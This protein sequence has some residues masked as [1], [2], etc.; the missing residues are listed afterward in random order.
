MQI[1]C[2][3]GFAAVN[4]GNRTAQFVR[5][6]AAVLG[7]KF[8]F[9]ELPAEE[10]V[11]FKDRV[12]RDILPL[13]SLEVEA[14][15]AMVDEHQDFVDAIGSG[16]RARVDARAGRDAV[17]VAEAVLE[18]IRTHRWPATGSDASPRLDA[19]APSILRPPHWQPVSPAPQPIRREAG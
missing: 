2:A 14:R 12:F 6:S 3:E 8:D 18:S 4:F 11:T 15:N 7:G 19:P 5:P 1:W 9:N 17:A 13:E 16:R 10:K